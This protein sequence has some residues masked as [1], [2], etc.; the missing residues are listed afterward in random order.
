MSLAQT[1]TETKLVFR[2]KGGLVRKRV[3]FTKETVDNENLDK[4]RSKACCIYHKSQECN[5]KE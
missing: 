5:L 1:S 3:T 2:L 4:K